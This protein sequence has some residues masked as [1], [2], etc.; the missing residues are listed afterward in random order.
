MDAL[1]PL[2]AAA[3]LVGTVVLVALVGILLDRVQAKQKGPASC[4][5]TGPIT[6]GNLT[7]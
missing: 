3:L 5:E 7:R 1:S 2:V 6:S 4:T